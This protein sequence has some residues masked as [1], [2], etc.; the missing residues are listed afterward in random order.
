M[1]GR[2]VMPI[3]TRPG[4]FKKCFMT[5]GTIIDRVITE[6]ED[7]LALQK[8][9]GLA[10]L[11]DSLGG[12]IAKTIENCRRY[13]SPYY[14]NQIRVL[15]RC[16]AIAEHQRGYW[17]LQLNPRAWSF[18]EGAGKNFYIPWCRKSTEIYTKHI[19]AALKELR[20]YHIGTCEL[21]KG[22]VPSPDDVGFAEDYCI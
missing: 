9:P 21:L 2:E 17:G 5:V 20:D 12:R 15:N 16:I 8:H 6:S 19:I 14:R 18:C 4:S 11:G 10:W 22:V 1:L 3:A 7:Q 13:Y